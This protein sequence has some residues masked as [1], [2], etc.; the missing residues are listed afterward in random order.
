MP[1]SE[2]TSLYEKKKVSAIDE[3]ESAP[4][5]IHLCGQY[6]EETKGRRAYDRLAEGS[7]GN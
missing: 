3:K 6:N 5:V 2:A 7:T 4:L 1:A